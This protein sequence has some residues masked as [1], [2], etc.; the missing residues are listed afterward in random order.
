MPI[1]EKRWVFPEPPG[2]ERLREI[3]QSLGCSPLLASL[4]LRRGLS[5]PVEARRF[6]EPSLEHFHDPFLLAGML[7]AADRLAQAVAD[8]EPITV[9]GDY[10]VDGVSSTAL[11][12]SFFRSIGAKADYYIPHRIKEG[13][14]LS[15]E[16]IEKALASGTKVIVTVDNGVAHPE[17]IRHAQKAGIDVIV[18][19]HHQVPEEGS[20]AFAMVNPH[21]EG[22]TYPFKILAGSGLALN[23]AIALRQRLRQAGRFRD[24]K[25]PNLKEFL[26]LACL[27]TIADLVPLRD[28]NRAISRFGIEEIRKT[29]RPGL[30]ALLALAT[31]DPGGLSAEDVAFRICPRI[32]AG[33]RLSDAQAAVELL[34]TSDGAEARMLAA[35]LDAHN[36]ERKALEK[37]MAEEAIARVEEQGLDKLKAIVVWKEGWHPGVIGIVAARLVERYHRPAIVIGVLNGEAKGSARSVPGYNVYEGIKSASAH[38]EGFGGHAQAAGFSIDPSKIGAFAQDFESNARAWIRPEHEEPLLQVDAEAAPEDLTPRAAGEIESL[39]P[40]G[41]ENP[42]PVL[43]VRSALLENARLLDG[44][45]LKGQLRTPGGRL[46]VIGFRMADRLPQ[47][48]FA[49]TLVLDLAGVLEWN[50]WRGTRR[51]QFNVKDVRKP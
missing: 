27:G 32:N 50:L 14:G 7:K 43:A 3:E 33:G 28:V 17:E 29:K 25:E 23:L 12:V 22:C 39:A 49:S 6:L 36:A 34:L 48:A 4:F 1:P 2:R 46:D 24:Q 37:E 42:R 31:E 44:G 40:F 45:H 26:D 11:L 8:Q 18:T 16:G 51:L 47:G 38:L 30:A 19:D 9:F 21:Q 41:M 13:Y 20:P 35:Q 15:Q 5:S 10:D